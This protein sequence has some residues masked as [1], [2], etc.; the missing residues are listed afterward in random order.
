MTNTLWDILAPNLQ[1]NLHGRLKSPGHRGGHIDQVSQSDGPVETHIV[2]AGRNNDSVG[3][4]LGRNGGT[5]IHPMQKA[6]PH[7][8]VER[9][10]VVG[11]NQLVHN[12]LGMR[13]GFGGSSH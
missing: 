8:V 1:T 9:I 4:F 5:D 2:H 7:Q 12:G 3:M 13:G 6:P 10:G 11:Q